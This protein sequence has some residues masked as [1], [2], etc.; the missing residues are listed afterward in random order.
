MN[1]IRK[2]LVREPTVVVD[3][4]FDSIIEDLLKNIVA[5]EWRVRQASCTAVADLVQGRPIENYEGYLQDIWTLTYK[6]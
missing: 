1:E 6:V 4:Y 2:A 5:R 3:K